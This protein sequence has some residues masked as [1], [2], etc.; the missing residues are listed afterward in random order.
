[1]LKRAPVSAQAFRSDSE[2][3]PATM[4]PR[5]TRLDQIQQ[6]KTVFPLQIGESQVRCA[7][8]NARIQPS[9][10]LSLNTAFERRA[11]ISIGSSRKFYCKC[12]TTP[13]VPRA[14][15]TP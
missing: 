1:M 2:F 11:I 14:K 8:V 12:A 13:F 3:V 6:Q 7:K 4:R 15:G 9:L 10:N 5:K